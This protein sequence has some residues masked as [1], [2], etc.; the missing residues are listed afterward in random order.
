MEHQ[1]QSR[2]LQLPNE[3]LL[4]IFE[5]TVTEEGPLLL[6][7]GCD[8]SYNSLEEW[9]E[10]QGQCLEYNHTSHETMS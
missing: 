7:C 10:D 1:Q 6:N 2:L 8:S 4:L 9:H 3:L 5:Y